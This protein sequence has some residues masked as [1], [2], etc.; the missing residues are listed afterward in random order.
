MEEYDFEKAADR[1]VMTF[2]RIKRQERKR[3]EPIWQGELGILTYLCGA[4]DGVRPGQIA[5]DLH[6]GSG[7]VANLLNGLEKKGLIER[8]MSQ[9]DRRCVTV[10]LSGEGREQIEQQKRAGRQRIAG[11][12]EKLGKEDAETLLRILDKILLIGEEEEAEC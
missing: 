6:I 3:S 10:R 8:S 5:K 12:L 11:R 2:L 4:P 9:T 1:L 7:G